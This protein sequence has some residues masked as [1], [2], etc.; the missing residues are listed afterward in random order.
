MAHHDVSGDVD[1]AAP[2]EIVGRLVDVDW[3][4]PHSVLHIEV[5]RD[6][7]ANQVWLVEADN[8]TQL[9]GRAFNA[10]TAIDL[11]VVSVIAFPSRSGSCV[12][13]C[14]AYG[15]SLRDPD[16]NSYTLNRELSNAFRDYRRRSS[17]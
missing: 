15:L 3:G 5:E 13:Q 10:G 14:G 4:N 8:A 12:D 16:N 2:V 11:D 9:A 17:Q 7:G 1:F 6:S